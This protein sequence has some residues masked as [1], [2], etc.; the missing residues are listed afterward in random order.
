VPHQAQNLN[1]SCLAT[2]SGLDSIAGSALAGAAIGGLGTGA[3]GVTGFPG[4]TGAGISTEIGAAGSSETDRETAETIC[5][6][7]V[8]IP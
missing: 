5:V 8:R 4:G 1:G 7:A 3:A 6:P 2:N